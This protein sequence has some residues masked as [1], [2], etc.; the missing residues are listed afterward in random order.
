MR[1]TFKQI[2]DIK[3]I[4][5]FNTIKQFSGSFNRQAFFSFCAC[6]NLS[7][8]KL[9]C[10]CL[11]IYICQSCQRPLFYSL[12]CFVKMGFSS[13]EKLMKANEYSSQSC[14]PI[15]TVDRIHVVTFIILRRLKCHWW[16]SHHLHYTI[17][18]YHMVSLNWCLH[19]FI[20]PLPTTC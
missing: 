2:F 20:E 17:F 19:C 12:S 7:V 14:Q 10:L 6:L 15:Y 4:Y 3:V 16:L 5:Q 13:L 1:V 8:S 18:S 11:E 9:E